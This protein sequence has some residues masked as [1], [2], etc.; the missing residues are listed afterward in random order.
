MTLEQRKEPIREEK[1]TLG[2]FE[3]RFLYFLRL[4]ILKN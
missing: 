4:D 3:S 1:Q 2:C